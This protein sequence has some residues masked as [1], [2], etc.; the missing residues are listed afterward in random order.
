MSSAASSSGT[1]P[2]F[3]P[4]GAISAGPAPAN[5]MGGAE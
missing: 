5:L 3:N 1:N 2:A 4:E